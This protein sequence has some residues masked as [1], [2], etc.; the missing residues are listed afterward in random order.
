MRP[1]FHRGW[2]SRTF[3]AITLVLL[4]LPSI[5][6]LS[7]LTRLSTEFTAGVAIIHCWFFS[8]FLHAAPFYQHY[9]LK[10][11][12]HL[13]LFPHLHVRILLLHSLLPVSEHEEDY[14]L[15]ITLGVPILSYITSSRA[16]ISS[17]SF[18]CPIGHS[19]LAHFAHRRTDAHCWPHLLDPQKTLPC[20]R[21]RGTPISLS[22]FYKSSFTREFTFW[23]HFTRILKIR[24]TSDTRLSPQLVALTY[25]TRLYRIISITLSLIQPSFLH[26]C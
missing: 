25:G 21:Y 4:P 15:H 12:C 1:Y 26:I 5:S 6:L 18:H 8:G 11:F 10:L 20:S 3:H 13:L 19:F 23:L 7:P 17:R 2:I 24:V 14:V 22:H 9:T 16:F